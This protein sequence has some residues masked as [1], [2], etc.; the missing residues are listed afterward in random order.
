MINAQVSIFNEWTNAQCSNALNH[1][2]IANSLTIASER[3][4]A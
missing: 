4:Q 2:F 3:R 1:C